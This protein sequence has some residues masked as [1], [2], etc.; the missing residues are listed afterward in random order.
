VPTFQACPGPS[1][2]CPI[3]LSCKLLHLA[4]LI[5]LTSHSL[6]YAQ[7]PQKSH[8]AVGAS[9]AGIITFW[10][11]TLKKYVASFTDNDSKTQQQIWE[12]KQPLA[13]LGK[14]SSSCFTVLPAHFPAVLSP[15]CFLSS[16]MSW[17][18]R[19]ETPC[20]SRANCRLNQFE[21]ARGTLWPSESSE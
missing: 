9:L 15:T 5:D 10:K 7:E 20:S 12:I 11:I 6:Q 16:Q 19:D 4:P 8:S 18:H 1:R 2:W 3:L 14:E 17:H 13:A 21:L